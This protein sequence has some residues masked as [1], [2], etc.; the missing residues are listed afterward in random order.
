M[1][2][3]AELKKDELTEQTKEFQ[4]L[5]NEAIKALPDKQVLYGWIVYS[6]GVLSVNAGDDKLKIIEK[7]IWDMKK[8]VRH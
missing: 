1:E 6:L 3:K 2:E 7:A 4:E 5:F 8:E